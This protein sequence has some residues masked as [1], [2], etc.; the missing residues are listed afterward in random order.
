MSETITSTEADEVSVSESMERIQLTIDGRSMMSHEIEHAIELAT[1]A[2]SSNTATSDEVRSSGGN[3]LSLT[4]VGLNIG[5]TEDLVRLIRQKKDWDSISLTNFLGDR[6]LCND[7]LLACTTH[8]SIRSL[9]WRTRIA[10]GIHVSA[11]TGNILAPTDSSALHALLYGLKYNSHLTRLEATGLILDVNMANLLSRALVRNTTLLDL[12]LNGTSFLSEN[13]S[14]SNQ[15]GHADENHRGTKNMTVQTLSFGL[16]FN[17]TIESLSLEM[18]NDL[19]DED[20]ACL[21]NAVNSDG[22]VLRRLSL[23]ETACFDQGMSSVAVLLQGNV[24]EDLNLNYLLRRR[25]KTPEREENQHEEEEQEPAEEERVHPELVE[26]NSDEEDKDE[27]ETKPAPDTDGI[28]RDQEDEQKQDEA[29]SKGTKSDQ[30]ANDNDKEQECQQVRNTSLKILSMAGN[31]LDDEYLE[32]LLGI[33]PPETNES[34]SSKEA[35]CCSHLEELNLLGNRFSNHGIK[36][37][38]KKL[39]RFP[40]LQRFYLGYQKAPPPSGP[41]TLPQAL[42][43]RMMTSNPSLSDRNAQFSPSSLRK[44]LVAAVSENP[45][46]FR[47]TNVNI[48]ALSNEDK[49][50]DRILRYHMKLNAGGRKLLASYA[51]SNTKSNFNAAAKDETETTA[52][53]TAVSSVP[54]GLWPLVLDR[55]NRVYPLSSIPSSCDNGRSPVST[56]AGGTNGSPSDHDG[57][58]VGDVIFCLLHGPMVFENLD[59]RPVQD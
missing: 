37:L 56:A 29:S 38:L 8:P 34:I 36:G 27:G 45:S 14:S 3:S 13:S 26:T 57:F 15:N 55:A 53:A 58:H 31:N 21:I 39:P 7:L 50:L 1:C 4:S 19:E 17:R 6:T 2:R 59:R 49:N 41:T 33:F 44:E 10:D 43:S 9:A 24:I 28:D 18:C 32:S 54:L 52:G 51:N 20:I 22:T 30:V 48:M 40:Y 35:L 5:L 23:Q 47:L 25:R 11:S 46:N 16:R 42:L 12:R